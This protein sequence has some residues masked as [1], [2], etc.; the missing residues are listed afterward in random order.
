MPGQNVTQALKFSCAE[1]IGASRDTRMEPWVCENGDSETAYG[2]SHLYAVRTHNAE[3]LMP[4]ASNCLHG[5]QIPK[6]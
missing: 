2:Q 3:V 4:R 1:G 5:T 6:K